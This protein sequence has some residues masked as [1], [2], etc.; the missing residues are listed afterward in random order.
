MIHKIEMDW[1]LNI[2]NVISIVVFL[3]AGVGAWYDVKSDVK[4]NHNEAQLKFLQVESFM[5]EQKNYNQYSERQRDVLLG[6]VKNAIRENSQDMK[7]ELRD[8]RNEVMNRHVIPQEQDR[9]KQL[10]K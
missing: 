2:G 4:L 5:S 7:S 1:S 3:L 6:E 9:V 10:K 8:L